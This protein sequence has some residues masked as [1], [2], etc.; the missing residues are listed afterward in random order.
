M[1]GTN[2]LWE[3]QSATQLLCVCV[4]VFESRKVDCSRS[5]VEKR[6]NSG[7]LQEMDLPEERNSDTPHPGTRRLE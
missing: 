7:T 2:S 1:P 5:P 6:F 4:C 3:L